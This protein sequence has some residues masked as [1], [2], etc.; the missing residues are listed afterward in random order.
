M[1]GLGRVVTGSKEPVTKK[2]CKIVSVSEK[3]ISGKSSKIE[4]FYRSW[5]N[6]AIDWKEGRREII[7]FGIERKIKSLKRAQIEIARLQHGFAATM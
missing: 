6:I 4:A 5:T 3:I 2:G 7:D 1:K